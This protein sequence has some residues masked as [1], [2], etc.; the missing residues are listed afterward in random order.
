[1]QEPNTYTLGSDR[2]ERERLQRQS[3]ELREEALALLRRVEL[4][5]GQRA[6]DIACGPCGIL[7]L[8]SERVGPRGAVVGLDRDRDHVELARAFAHERSLANVRVLEGDARETHLPAASFDLVHARLLLVNV[9]RPDEVLREMVRV[10]RSGG[11]VAS[12]EVDALLLCEPSH[13]A[14]E[15]LGA[16]FEATYDQEG[17][18]VHIGRRLPELYR[19]A[20]L[21]DVGVAIHTAHH[22]GGDTRHTILPDLVRPMRAKI[23]TRQIACEGELDALDAAVRAHLDTPGTMTVPHLLFSV[24]GRKP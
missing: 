19:D 22:V 10:V 16:I 8:L 18:D 13:P 2:A 3:L 5:S 11:W 21:V 1:M 20:G 15:R 7:D 6:I 24:W 12:Q 14:W 9:P 23:L 17:A 4:H